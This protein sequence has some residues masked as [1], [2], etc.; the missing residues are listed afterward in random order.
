MDEALLHVVLAR[1]DRVP[2]AEEGASLLLAAC[3]SDDALTAKLCG[4]DRKGHNNC[5]ADRLLAAGPPV[6]RPR[7]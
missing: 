2:L 3:E 5:D 1:L 7:G 4:E 6:R